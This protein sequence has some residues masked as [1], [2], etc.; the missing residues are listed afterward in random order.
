MDN[1][2]EIENFDELAEALAEFDDFDEAQDFQIETR[3]AILA[4]NNMIALLCLKTAE[5][6]GAICRID[7]R[8]DRPAV[9]IYDNAA[10]AIDWYNQ[11]LITSRENGWTIAYDGLPL[12]G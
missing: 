1:D 9:Q 7:P 11:S 6:G 12:R 5:Q 2:F 8:E 3:T 10:S 4:K